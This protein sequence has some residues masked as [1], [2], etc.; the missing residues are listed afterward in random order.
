MTIC[1]ENIGKTYNGR[2]VLSDFNLDVEDDR[3]YAIIGASGSGKTT[4][5]KIFMGDIKPDSGRVAC[6]GDYKYP[7]L[8]SAYVPQEN[9]YKP[10]KS[11]IWHLRKA[12]RTIT[13]ENA[14]EELSR[15]LTEDEQNM[16]MGELSDTKQ[17]L[18]AIVK[19]I[20][21]HAD[22]IV[23]D[24]PFTG[25]D[26]ELTERAKEYILSKRGRRPLLITAQKEEGLEFARK[27]FIYN[28]N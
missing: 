6:M 7:N 14:M 15:F 21:L 19:A 1:L 18:V 8:R 4:I 9:D 2:V 17:R 20:M 5:L 25:M 10:R 22:F 28:Q 27:R 11:P 12:D 23:L 3:C 16:P 24:E 26:P 13:K